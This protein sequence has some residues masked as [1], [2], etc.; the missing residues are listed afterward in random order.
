MSRLRMQY[1]GAF[2]DFELNSEMRRRLETTFQHKFVKVIEVR[3]LT[4]DNLHSP[5]ELRPGN[6]LLLKSFFVY[7]KLFDERFVIPLPAVVLL[8][9]FRKEANFALPD[10]LKSLMSPNVDP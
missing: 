8:K 3:T 2:E 6:K 7:A 9:N 10:F 4:T 1:G 5:I